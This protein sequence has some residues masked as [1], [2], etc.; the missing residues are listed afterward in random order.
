MGST[1]CSKVRPLGYLFSVW[2]AWHRGSIRP[3]MY[4]SGDFHHDACGLIQFYTGRLCQRCNDGYYSWFGKCLQC[5]ESMGWT[6]KNALT[7]RNPDF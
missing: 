7:V 2:R 3:P 4:A 1:N 6:A 5:P